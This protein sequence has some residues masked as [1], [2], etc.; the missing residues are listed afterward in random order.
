MKS[1]ERPMTIDDLENANARMS[2]I[3]FYPT[4]PEA[5]AEIQFDLG[6]MC[7]SA[8]VLEWLVDVARCEWTAWQGTAGLRRI[9]TRRF[10][11]AD[12]REE[13]LDGEAR[14]LELQ[15]AAYNDTV[16][17]WKREAKML[18]AA[19]PKLL[20]GDAPAVEV[21]EPVAIPPKV[22]L[23]EPATEEE[24]QPGPKRGSSA[25]ALLLAELEMRLRDRIT[26][27]AA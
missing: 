15:A 17:Q 11:P 9:L 7:R 14:Y 16:Q 21:L 12:A 6:Q 2:T 8:E 25:N 1:N 23:A 3:P 5:K 13:Q 27:A 10:K 20:T 18:E 24:L 26:G 22:I 19:V 4:L